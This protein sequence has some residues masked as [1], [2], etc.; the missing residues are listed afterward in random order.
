MMGAQKVA[1]AHRDSGEIIPP[2]TRQEEVPSAIR[3]NENFCKT[4]RLVAKQKHLEDV[5]LN[6]HSIV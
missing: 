5:T 2:R 4:R 1:K 3:S 6:N